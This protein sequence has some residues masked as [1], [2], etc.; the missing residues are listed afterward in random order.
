MLPSFFVSVLGV[1]QPKTIH[2]T[3]KTFSDVGVLDSWDVYWTSLIH[4]CPQFVKVLQFIFINSS[5]FSQKWSQLGHSNTIRILCDI[6]LC[7]FGLFEKLLPLFVPGILFLLQLLLFL[8]FLQF[9]PF[10]AQF[11]TQCL[12]LFSVPLSEGVVIVIFHI[13][14]KN[15][16]IS[17]IIIFLGAYS[18]L[19][20]L[21]RSFGRVW[22]SPWELLNQSALLFTVWTR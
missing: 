3:L 13:V 5:K 8:V 9:L 15:Q 17:Q 6:S 14:D 2:Y 1:F 18:E 20:R 7:S 12:V 21:E 16:N 4:G 10:L 11:G 19:A 22:F